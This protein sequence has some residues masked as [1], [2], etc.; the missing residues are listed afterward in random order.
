MLCGHDPDGGRWVFR[1]WSGDWTVPKQDLAGSY[2]PAAL[3]APPPTRMF[4]AGSTS[5]VGALAPR[6]VCG[7]VAVIMPPVPKAGLGAPEVVKRSILKAVIAR[8]EPQA[9]T[10]LLRLQD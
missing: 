3:L 8:H 2:E 10:V 9:L 6:A 7:N 4:P 1:G 5:T